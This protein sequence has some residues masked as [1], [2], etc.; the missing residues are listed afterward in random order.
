VLTGWMDPTLM[1]ECDL[2]AGVSVDPGPV[3]RAEDLARGRVDGDPR[4]QG[5]CGISALLLGDTDGDGVGEYAVGCERD[6]TL[7]VY[8]GMP[9]GVLLDSDADTVVRFNGSTT[10][11]LEQGALL[12]PGTHAVAV[13]GYLD[14][15]TYVLSLPLPLGDWDGDDLA[16][17][18]VLGDGASYRGG[19]LSVGDWNLDGTD[20]L[21]VSGLTDGFARPEGGVNLLFG[22]FVSTRIGLE[23]EVRV[24]VDDQDA[25]W[26]LNFGNSGNY[27]RSLLPD[28]DGD[29]YPEF[30]LGGE[31]NRNLRPPYDESL[32]PHG[33]LWLFDGGPGIVG[34]LGA[35]DARAHLYGSCDAQWDANTLKSIGD[36][37]G[38]CL[39]DIAMGSTALDLG[40]GLFRGGVVVLS[41]LRRVRGTLPIERAASAIIIGEEAGDQLTT[42]SY[43]GDWNQDGYDELVIGARRSFGAEGKVYIFLGPVSGN[44]AAA[45]ADLVLIGGDPYGVFGDEIRGGRDLDGDGVPDLLVG[46]MGSSSSGV[47]YSGSLFVFSGADLLAAM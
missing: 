2:T 10:T 15:T 39:P 42:T 46:A 24:A 13:G 5:R 19:I 37:T 27:S 31:F 18:R 1:D 36:V 32:P 4:R 7:L 35:A 20:D 28:L 30:G 43:V 8:E 33:G 9:T 26:A 21:T 3:V 38:D 34:E 14:T 44:L 12:G 45:D 23:S 6:G 29:G 11:F 47:D 22:P 17:G 41:E 40:G 16:A 25:S